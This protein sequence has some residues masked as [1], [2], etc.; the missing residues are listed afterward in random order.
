MTRI[1][2]ASTRSAIRTAPGCVLL[3]WVAFGC[4]EGRTERTVPQPSH[5]P[6][7]LVDHAVFDSL[8]RE[9]VR[10][11]RVD[12]AAIRKHDA[13]RLRDYLTR[14]AGVE[15]DR[16]ATSERLAFYIN[17]YNA[18]MIQAVV[19]RLRPG[20]S[21]QDNDFAVFKEPLVGLRGGRVSLDHL[22]NQII[23]KQFAEPRIHVALVCGARSCPPLLPRAYTGADL[24]QLLDANMRRFVADPTRNRIDP[25]HGVLELSKIF[26]WYAADFGGPEAL[27]GFLQKYVTADLAGSKPTFRAY[28]WELN[29]VPDAPR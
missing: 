29:I 16:L 22:E 5:A 21:P 12:Y 19:D 2:G 26:E 17:L 18:T 8:L 6:A 13:A 27:V 3:V 28:S 24:E 14:L 23:R 11:Q 9:R 4:A 15:P 7:Q 20:Y 10:D 1:T 25:A